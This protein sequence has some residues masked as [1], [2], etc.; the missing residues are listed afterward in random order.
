[1]R[2][3]LESLCFQ[4]CGSVG[5]GILGIS[6][7]LSRFSSTLRLKRWLGI[8]EGNLLLDSVRK[9][10]F[11]GIKIHIKLIEKSESEENQGTP[12]FQTKYER[13]TKYYPITDLTQA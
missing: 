6:R 5:A 3:T 11:R 12:I 7:C 13:N 4:A 2:C 10:C 9:K 1:M 8:R